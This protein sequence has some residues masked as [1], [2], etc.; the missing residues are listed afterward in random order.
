MKI[1]MGFSSRNGR[2]GRLIWAAFTL[3]ELLLTVVLLLLLL[4]AVVFNYS[5]LARG[6]RLDH[7]AEQLETLFRF[8]RSQAASTGRQVRIV[9]ENPSSEGRG[10]T[11]QAPSGREN[12]P[13]SSSGGAG[14]IASRGT[15]A[16]VMVVWE[17]DPY[18]APGQFV[19]LREAQSYL[20]DILDLIE[21]I[22]VRLPGAKR[23]A[24]AVSWNGYSA[25]ATNAIPT[26]GSSP[27]DSA[28]PSDGTAVELTGAPAQVAFYPD[29]SSDSFEVIIGSQEPEDTRRLLLSLA[30]VTG[31][32]QLKTLDTDADGRPVEESGSGD[33]SDA[34]GWA[35]G[36]QNPALKSVPTQQPVSP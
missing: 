13:P 32:V 25:V 12:G 24:T 30:G 15:N 4:G 3:V 5:S 35:P 16:P 36:L 7:G 18:G 11:H 8:A 31:R 26:V 33:R 29:G 22:E 28:V 20:E 14:S 21:V 1:I 34:Q 17:P 6:A 2:H 10:E 19:P 9:F 23:P 27:Q